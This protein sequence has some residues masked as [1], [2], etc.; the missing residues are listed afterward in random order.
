MKTITKTAPLSRFYTPAELT[1][2]IT[3][4]M[5]DFAA[6]VSKKEIAERFNSMCGD[7]PVHRQTIEAWLH[8]D[9]SKRQIPSLG[10][11]IILRAVIFMMRSPGAPPSEVHF[12]FPRKPRKTN[13]KK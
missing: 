7:L 9:R 4:E 11:A 5:A 2:L 12:N 6:G 8:P 13:H 1:D 3:Q 10:A